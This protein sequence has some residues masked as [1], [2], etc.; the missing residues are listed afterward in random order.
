MAEKYNPLGGVQQCYRQQMDGSCHKA[1]S[2]AAIVISLL[3][4]LSG[5]ESNPGPA[6][7]LLPHSTDKTL[8]FGLL[9]SAMFRAPQHPQLWGGRRP[10]K[11]AQPSRKKFFE[12]N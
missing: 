6:S 2:P 11:W 4:L 7:S 1:R 8:N 5:V 9:N 10:C 12:E 3:L